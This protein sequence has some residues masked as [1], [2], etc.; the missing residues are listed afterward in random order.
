MKEEIAYHFR[1]KENLERNL[2]KSICI[3]PFYVNVLPMKEF[4]IDKIW[5]VAKCLLEMFTTRLR[6]QLNENIA[7]YTDIRNRLIEEPQH[8]ER[9]FELCEW[10]ETIPLT[11]RSIDENVQRLQLEYDILDHFWWN[12]S[13]EDFQAK[14]GTIGFP[15]QIKLQVSIEE[16]CLFQMKRN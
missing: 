4:L 8:I 9:I 10:I 16:E 2:P 14:W 7:D 5:H 11:V 6:D 1:M 3:G 13:D 15:Q 12:L